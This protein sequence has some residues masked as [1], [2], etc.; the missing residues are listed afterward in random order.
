MNGGRNARKTLREAA[1]LLRSPQRTVP[2]ICKLVSDAVG[3]CLPQRH[4][5]SYARTRCSTETALNRVLRWILAAQ[6]ADGGIA[7]Y[8][9]LLSGYSASYPEVTGYIIPTLYSFARQSSGHA[10]L[11]AISAAECATDWLLKLQ[12]PNGAFPAGLHAAF[13]QPS[14]FNTG[15]ILHGLI[16]SYSETS[17]PRVYLAAT[18]AG[19][20]LIERQQLDG[21]WSGAGAYQGS[22]HS[23]YSM[24]A[25]SLAL[26]AEKTGDSRYREAAAKNLDWLLSCFQPNGWI[27]RINLH[28]HP[29]YL[30]FTA[31][32]LQG[33]LECGM[34]CQRDDAIEAVANSAWV[35]LR[36]FETQKFLCGAYEDNFT[37]SGHFAC[38]TGNAQM[39][40]VWLRLFEIVGDLRYLNA[41]L[42][43]NEMLK[44]KIPMRG[45]HGI[46]GGVS[47]SYPIWGSYQPLRYIS[48]GCKFVAD[49]FLLEQSIKRSLDSSA[50][51]ALACAS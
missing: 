24:V 12:M 15:Q 21:S 39:S 1:G 22:A 49:A 40:C 46:A 17:H 3:T 4:L 26:L 51:E 36:H 44:E 30:H 19:D 9:S 45:K 14:I 41:A 32:A 20:W 38:L 50:V 16:R 34:L 48:W 47:G 25:W 23:Y 28:G 37:K 8:Y 2:L 11:E 18:C 13:S 6:R 33:A 42:K 31:Y 29:D 43:M 35:L 10:G 7:A 27:S 5:Y